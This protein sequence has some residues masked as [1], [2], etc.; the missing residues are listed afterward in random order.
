MDLT[1]LESI[2]LTTGESKVYI[3]LLELGPSNVGKIIKKAKISRSKIYDVLSRLQQKGLVTFVKEGK[4]QKFNAFQPKQLTEYIN[5]QQQELTQREET[6]LHLIPQ[7]EKITPPS[8]N[9]SAEI[10]LGPRGIKAFFEMSLHENPKKEEILILGYSKD[11]SLYYHAYFRQHLKE[12]LK[13]KIPSK[14][15]YDYETWQLKQ[16]NKRRLEQQRYLPKGFKTPAFIY[17]FGNI[18]GT[19]VF[20]KQQKLCFMVKNKEVADSY[21]QYFN[22][23]WNQAIKPNFSKLNKN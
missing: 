14:V 5:K 15:I 10:L 1:S 16:R 9:T 4:I 19:I 7:L 23:L 13:L 6:L 11:A 2:G 20:T 8:K 3:S 18:V 22:M 17:I 12:K 21:K